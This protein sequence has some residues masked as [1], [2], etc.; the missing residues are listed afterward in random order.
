MTDAFE[1]WLNQ[2]HTTIRNGLLEHYG[3]LGLT[4]T[5]LVFVIQ[6]QSYFNQ[7]IYF[8]NLGEIALRMGKKEAEIFTVLHA[9]IQKKCISITSEKDEAGMVSDRYSLNPLYKKLSLLFERENDRPE[10]DKDEVNLLEVFQQEFGR[11]LT[12]IEMQTIGEWLDKDYYS[13][14]IILEA[15]REAVL[16]QKYSLKYMDRILM[17]WEKKN[18]KTTYQAKEESKRFYQSHHAPVEEEWDDEEDIPLF[19]WLES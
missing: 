5:E 2:G 17:S 1:R 14:D 8:P 15:L 13:K 12:P 16:N 10:G 9:L 18:I 19:N 11:L 4:E 3:A 7:N 6:L